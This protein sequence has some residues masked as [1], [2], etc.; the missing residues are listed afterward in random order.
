MVCIRNIC[1]NTLHK[2][3]N[4]D[5]DYDDDNNLHGQNN[6]PCAFY[7]LRNHTFSKY[8]LSWRRS[9]IALWFK[10]FFSNVMALDGGHV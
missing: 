2:G 10:R 3:D 4:N 1:I 7:T 9:D 6:K 8:R 5:D